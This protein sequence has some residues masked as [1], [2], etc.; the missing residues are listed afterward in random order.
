MFRGIEKKTD[1]LIQNDDKES[2]KKTQ[3]P[4]VFL[5]KRCY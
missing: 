4:E 5:K 2:K 1:L 3:P